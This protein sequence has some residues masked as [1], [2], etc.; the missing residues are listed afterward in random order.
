MRI[1]FLEI[2]N[3]RKLKSTHLDLDKKI[4]ILVGANNSGKT[5]A[6]VALRM[7]LL[8]P[9]RLA[10]RGI[11]I[12]NWI[13]IDTLGDEWEKEQEPSIEIDTLLPTLDVWLDVPIGE[14]QH[15]AHILP[16]LNWAGGLLGVRL[17]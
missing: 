1:K 4:T 11:T 3:F 5:S 13:Q 16:T 6:M 15:V 9:N 17:Q 8:C 2:T 12:A 10:L 7:F 14:I